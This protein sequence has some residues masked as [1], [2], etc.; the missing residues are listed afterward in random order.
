MNKVDFL[1]P[2]RT[3][4]MR[5]IGDYRQLNDALF[6]A[7][8]ELGL[9][10]RVRRH[11]QPPALLRAR[12]VTRRDR[13]AVTTTSAIRN[14]DGAGPHTR[15]VAR[16]A[17]DAGAE[18][19]GVSTCTFKL[20]NTGATAPTDPAAAPAGRDA[21]RSTT[22]STGCRPRPPARAGRRSCATR[23]PR[24]SRRERRRAG[25]HPRPRT[26][27]QDTVTLTATSVS[28]PTKTATATCA[29]TQT[30]GTVGGSVPATLVADA[31]HAGGVRRLHAGRRRRTTS[32]RR[33][34]T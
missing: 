18:P 4:V 33:R 11:G 2:R 8:T 29:L 6:H 20:T 31:R 24:P 13:R 25:L 15:G 21:R 10:V 23:S 5:T 12:Q 28:D 32:P 26:R 9:A 3:P 16:R 22:T 14:L 7:G 19:G 1:R 34:P 27:R 30:G 17:A